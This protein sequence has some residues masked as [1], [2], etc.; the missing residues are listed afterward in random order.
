MRFEVSTKKRHARGKGSKG[1]SPPYA[2][3][4]KWCS[5]MTAELISQLESCADGRIARNA[6]LRHRVHRL[7]DTLTSHLQS[8][9]QL[10][11]FP[12]RDAEAARVRC[13]MLV[14]DSDVL[15]SECIML[16]AEAEE[17]VRET[18]APRTLAESEE[19]RKGD[20]GQG[21]ESEGGEDVECSGLLDKLR[22]HDGRRKLVMELKELEAIREEV[23]EWVG[24]VL[25]RRFA[26][27]GTAR[28]VE[29]L[30]V[31]VV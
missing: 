12:P 14:H 22:A 25:E 7:H 31:G 30:A 21:V 5:D 26:A 13:M 19:S 18:R 6:A 2:E 29:G 8:T 1:R 27:D 10:L 4:V 15:E 9:Q 23:E 28:R 3:R 24:R 20:E 16:E 11:A 17:V